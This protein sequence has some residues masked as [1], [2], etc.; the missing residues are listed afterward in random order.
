MEIL[1]T[2]IYYIIFIDIL[3]V[4]EFNVYTNIR[5]TETVYKNIFPNYK[6]L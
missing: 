6:T 4:H 5:C 2:F 1:V 3:E